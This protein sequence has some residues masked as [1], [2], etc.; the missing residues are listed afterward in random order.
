MSKCL[1]EDISGPASRCAVLHCVV[2]CGAVSC[3]VLCRPVLMLRLWMRM[4][5]R[6]QV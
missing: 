5:M 1:Y 3:F 4:R 6:L 2:S